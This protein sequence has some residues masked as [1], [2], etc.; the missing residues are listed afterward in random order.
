MSRR[1]DQVL[2]RKARKAEAERLVEMLSADL[3]SLHAVVGE[4]HTLLTSA[5][6]DMDVAM[7]L[8]LRATN[9]DHLA[10]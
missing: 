6:I 7:A 3:D 10:P 4:I 1:K 5:D 2:V 9:T 8:R